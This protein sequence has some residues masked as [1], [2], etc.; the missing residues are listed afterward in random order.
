LRHERRR[1]PGR[2]DGH[3]LIG[4][5][6]GITKSLHASDLVGSDPLITPLQ[7]NGG[8][9]LTH[10]LL[11]GS[12]AL[13][14]GNPTLPNGELNACQPVDQREP[15][16]RGEPSF[17]AVRCPVGQLRASVTAL[18]PPGAHQDAHAGTWA[19]TGGPMGRHR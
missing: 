14:A 12:P 15:E 8:A 6:T 5:S 3:N 7:D 11:A 9:T 10:G 19:V 2:S 16:L 17:T 13:D 18:V 4:S 1:L